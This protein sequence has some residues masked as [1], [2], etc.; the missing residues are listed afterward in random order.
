M[1]AAFGTAAS[2]FES[3][4]NDAVT[5]N[6]TV[7]WGSV[8]GNT[9]GAG[10]LGS[11]WVPWYT[12]Y[13]LAQ[14]TSYLTA[15]KSSAN[16]VSGISNLGLTSPAGNSFVVPFAEAKALGM[17]PGNRTAVD[18][19]IGFGYTPASY[20]LS[21][22]APVASGTYDFVGVAA[23]EI[24]EVLGRLSTLNG[25]SSPTSATIF[26]LFRYG[27]PGVEN[28]SRS[29]ASYFSIDG[30]ITNLNP[31]NV[32]GGGDRSD[33]GA[34]T[35]TAFDIQQAY[36]PS[37]KRLVIS[38]ADLVALDVLGWDSNAAVTAGPTGTTG[39]GITAASV[40]EPASVS[41]LM[42]AVMTLPILRR[43]R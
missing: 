20:T 23:H 24:E 11:S 33:W 18:G 35:G 8:K 40:A 13:S 16:D 5:V 15:A 17:I 21:S 32:S 14:V 29:A 22:T 36:L 6:I 7:S 12:G 25:S 2:L 34:T 28:F 38:P 10:V 30:G 19:Y 1:K 37:G 42:L 43:R 27:A 3:T 9:I 31:F 41:L 39:G 4:F 26:D